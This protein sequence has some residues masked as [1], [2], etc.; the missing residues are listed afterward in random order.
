MTWRPG[1]VVD[2]RGILVRIIFPFSGS[3]TGFGACAA[4]YPIWYPGFCGCLIKWIMSGALPPLFPCL[5]AYT[6]PVQE[7][8]AVCL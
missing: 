3:Y 2:D 6:W 8:R 4:F 7:V 1:Y 5:M